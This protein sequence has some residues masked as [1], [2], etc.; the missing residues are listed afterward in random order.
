MLA[1]LAAKGDTARAALCFWGQPGTGKTELAHHIAKSLGRTLTVKLGSDLRCK[2]VGGTERNIANMFKTAA[3]VAA[4]SVLL[5]DEADSLLR[6]RSQAQQS[7]EVD[8]TNEFLAQM[9][10][11]P[12]LFICTTNLFAQLDPAVLRRFQFRLEFL[13]LDAAQAR[14]MF[15]HSFG[16]LAELS[17]A[18][19]K[20][21][22]KL[23][24]L[25]PA[26][27][28]NVRRQVDFMG[29]Q[30]DAAQLIEQL[31]DELYTRRG[32]SGARAAGMG[33]V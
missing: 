27:F 18:D 23:R 4:S 17:E 24:E 16:D 32:Q 10:S 28:A 21:L 6:D 30:P 15:A 14:E 13:C 19:A 2:W 8:F 29:A 26:D 33:F 11:F 1:A 12:G 7:F 20:K 5:L 22:D 25:V 31:N 3:Q 9:E